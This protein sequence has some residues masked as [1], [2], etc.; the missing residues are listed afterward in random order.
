MQLGFM[1]N[2]QRDPLAEA[3]WAAANG[4]G[5]LDLTIEG[6]RA[7]LEQINAAAIR[8]VLDAAGMGVVG[9][10][11]PYLPFAAPFAGVRAAAAAEVIAQLPTFAAVGATVV[12]VHMTDGQSIFGREYNQKLLGATFATLAEAAAAHGIQIVAEHA[13]DARWGV[14]EIR[15]VLDADL[16]LGFHLDVGHA[17]VG[18]DRLAGL[19]DAFAPR[20]RHV[21]LSDNRGRND[22]HMPIG[23]GRIDWPRALRLLKATGY[24]GTITLEVFDQDHDYLLLSARKVREWWA[25]A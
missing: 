7:A 4:F 5:F 21:H 14:A 2:P 12:N 13:P 17:Y 15:A 19:L 11:A 1:N 20:L 10:T 23:A 3:R 24:D 8:A 25:A 6:P 22:D 18:G 9:H 16:R